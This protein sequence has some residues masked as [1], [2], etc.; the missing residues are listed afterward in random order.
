MPKALIKTPAAKAAAL[1]LLAGIRTFSALIIST[2]LLQR[3]PLHGLT[4]T[5][6]S[7]MQSP[8]MAL[9]F[10]IMGIAELTGDKL[11]CTP[12]RTSPGGLTG[13]C[14][15]GCL[16]GAAIYK[17][18]GRKAC[19]GGLIGLATAAVSTFA[20]FCLR[21]AIVKATDMPDPYVGAA[22]DLI[23]IGAGLNVIRNNQ[24]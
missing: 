20:A 6:L 13:R 18:A 8:K 11:P 23:V 12:N 17:A 10:K 3:K 16:S 5:P 19:V 2:E 21:R 9:A 22:E 15:A 14:L 1:G 24:S 4:G 7:F